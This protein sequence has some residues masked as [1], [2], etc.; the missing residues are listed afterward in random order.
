MSS[1]GSPAISYNAVLPSLVHLSRYIRTDGIPRWSFYIGMGQN[2]FPE[3]LSSPFTTLIILLP[4]DKIP[5]GMAWLEVLKIVLAGLCFYGYL[6][7]MGL[8]K[9]TGFAGSLLY[10]F[11][12]FIIVGS[13]WYSYSATGVSVALLLLAFEKLYRKNDARWF[14]PAV[15]LLGASVFSLYTYGMFLL[16]YSLVRFLD[17]NR[18]NVRLYSL[19]LLKMAGLGAL[20]IAISFICFIGGALHILQSPRVSGHVGYFQSL[21]QVPVFGLENWSITR[22][23][24]GVPFLHLKTAVLRMFSSDIMGIGE[25]FRG[26]YN[27]LEAPLFYCGLVTLLLVPSMFA[28]LDKRRK[29]LFGIFAAIWVLIV[30]FPYFRYAYNLF[31][32]DYYKT[33]ISLIVSLVMLLYGLRALDYYDR[34][35]RPNPW[36]LFGSYCGLMALLFG[37]NFPDRP[38]IVQDD[39]RLSVAAFLTIYAA[40]IYLMRFAAFRNIAKIALLATLIIEVATF[41]HAS[42]NQRLTM[43]GRE[44][45]EER[46]GYNDFSV[47]AAAYL[48]RI[49]HGFYRVTKDYFSGTAIHTSFNDAQ[50]Q[51]FFGTRSYSS[52][53]QLSY[54]D[55]LQETGVISDTEETATRWIIGLRNRPVLQSLCSVKYNLTKSPAAGFYRTGFDSI[56]QFGDVTVER[57]DYFLPLG[58]T[59]EKYVPLGTMMKME[60][61]MRRLIMLTA[62]VLDDSLV[63][64]AAGL[65]SPDP[66]DTGRL[67]FT[68][69]SNGNPVAIARFRADIENLKRDTLALT[70]HRENHLKGTISLPQKK[71]MFF[72]I[73]FDRGWHAKVDGRTVPLY[74]VNFGFTGLPVEAG[75]TELNSVSIRPSG[76]WGWG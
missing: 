40:L 8:T 21:R 33:G 46:T 60:G 56:A 18:W 43:T 70:V 51:D 68:G 27:Y 54:V 65:G 30:I 32:G 5:F 10:A 20:G 29:W 31:A 23:S 41:S 13:A 36:Y 48:K 4:F 49:D 45:A 76:G 62:C 12:G 28:A 66:A 61:R 72:S 57:N 42:V 22:A 9:F 39:V 16:L 19:L 26:W 64:M 3:G 52:F 69:L 59:Y 71:I 53:N 67:Y 24:W 74:K 55:F 17:E 47:D 44:L 1:R 11:S 15:A 7:T 2:V 25:Y 50:I 38:G 58:F 63:T 14:P 73:P 37:I 75:T 35:P 6:R 34:T